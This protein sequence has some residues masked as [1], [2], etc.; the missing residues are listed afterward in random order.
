MDI[1]SLILNLEYHKGKHG[2]I[3]VLIDTPNELFRI[4]GI[5]YHED[6][7]ALILSVLAVD[8]GGD[9]Q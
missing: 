3:P 4:G 9:E 1:I 8:D 5:W 7:N 6:R 2:S